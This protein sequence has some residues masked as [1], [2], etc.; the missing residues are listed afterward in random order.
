MY[1]NGNKLDRG[2]EG[3]LWCVCRGLV[4]LYISLQLTNKNCVHK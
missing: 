3:R 2:E 4:T 1:R